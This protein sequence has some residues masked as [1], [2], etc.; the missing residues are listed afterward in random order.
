MQKMIDSL[1]A[2]LKTLNET[3]LFTLRET[4]DKGHE[5]LMQEKVTS[6]N[7]QSKIDSLNKEL[8]DTKKQL[9]DLQLKMQTQK[10]TLLRQIDWQQKVI[11]DH[12]GIERL[13]ELVG[14]QEVVLNF[15]GTPGVVYGK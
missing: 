13:R 10:Q 1:R 8:T 4:S 2:E 12:V 11:K 15:N 6:I 9:Y 5:A 7:L 14:E 3:S